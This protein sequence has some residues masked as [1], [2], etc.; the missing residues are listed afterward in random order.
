MSE[1]L[2]IYGSEKTNAAIETMQKLLNAHPDKGDI[3]TND[4]ARGAKYVP[5]NVIERKLDEMYNGLWQTTNF[6]CEV[7]YNEIIGI[8]DLQV[9][10]PAAKIWITRTGL[11]SV[12][13]QTAAGKPVSHENKIKNTLVKDFPK[14]RSECIKNAAKSLGVVFGRNLNRGMDDDYTYLS[15]TVATT[16]EGVAEAEQ[17][18]NSAVLT[19]NERNQVEAK[20]GRATPKTIKAIVEFLKTKQS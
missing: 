6:R 8:V 12:M 10:H 2:T 20:I 1:E 15:E 16:I 19:D 5:I 17:L 7:V 3:K 11:A 14:L 13:I 4:Q 18:L 9:F